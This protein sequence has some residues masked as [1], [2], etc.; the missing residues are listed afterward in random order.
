MKM[1]FRWYGSCS[2][3]GTLNIKKITNTMI[4]SRQHPEY[5]AASILFT[6]L[7]EKF[8]ACRRKACPRR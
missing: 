6:I 4:G 2:D 1:T 3:S 8:I 7:A 5:G